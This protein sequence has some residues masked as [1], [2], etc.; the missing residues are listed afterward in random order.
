METSASS[1]NVNDNGL[2]IFKIPLADDGNGK[3]KTLN[4]SVSSVTP[5]RESSVAI[6]EPI[7]LHL[8][9]LVFQ[10]ENQIIQDM[11]IPIRI[12]LVE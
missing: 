10:E 12:I 6:L 2:N 8:E 9:L 1:V 3:G 5:S 7:C 11:R 4:T